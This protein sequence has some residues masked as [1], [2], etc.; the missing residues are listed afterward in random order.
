MERRNRAEDADGRG[1]EEHRA[2]AVQLIGDA[3][4]GHARGDPDLLGRVGD[5]RRSAWRDH[6]LVERGS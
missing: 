5:A 3:E 2:Q 6:A 1:R 4:D